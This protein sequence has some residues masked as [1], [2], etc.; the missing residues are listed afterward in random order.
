MAGEPQRCPLA[1]SWRQVGA[2]LVISIDVCA[3]PHPPV[4]DFSK[5]FGICYIA[6]ISSQDIESKDVA[7]MIFVFS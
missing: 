5:I 4:G 7:T 6:K 3:S 2:A 1:D